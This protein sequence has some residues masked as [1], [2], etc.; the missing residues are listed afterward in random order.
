MIGGVTA[1]GKPAI[2]LPNQTSIGDLVLVYRT[3]LSM[4]LV[5]PDRRYACM[6]DPSFLRQSF[7]RIPVRATP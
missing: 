1:F 3:S 5:V 4:G 7:V 2:H 6:T